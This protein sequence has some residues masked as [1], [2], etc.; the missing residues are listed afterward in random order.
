MR[1]LVVCIYACS[2]ALLPGM[3]R[4]QQPSPQ[5][6]GR[7]VRSSDSLPLQGVEVQLIP[8]FVAG[9]LNFQKAISDAGG[10]YQFFGVKEGTYSI[11]ATA[12]GYVS[13]TYKRD[14][15]PES[16][17][18]QIDVSTRIKGIDFRLEPEAV[19]QGSVVNPERKPVEG[20]SVA[21]VRKE[22]REDG[23]Q[24]LLPV[25]AT[26]T[27]VEGHFAL[28]GLPSGTYFVCV[29]GPQGFGLYTDASVAY[30]ETWYASAATIEGAIPLSLHQ[31]QQLT[32]LQIAVEQERLFHVIVRP[33]GP[34]AAPE[35]DRYDVIL[36]NR[37]HSST[38]M[39]DGSYMI[40][41][42]PA[43]HYTVV[44]TAWSGTTYVGQGEAEFN[45]VDADVTVDVAVGGLG[46]V[47]G[48][49]TEEAGTARPIVDVMIGIT[50]QEG[51]AQGKKITA[52]RSFQFDGVL[53]GRYSFRLLQPLDHLKLGSVRC[54][55]VEVNLA[56]PLLVGAEQ[57]ITGCTVSLIQ[58]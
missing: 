15:S 18:T 35:I 57:R 54:M 30:Q 42:I 1:I 48:V 27:D 25:S 2:L 53:P 14:T 45:V 50:S 9:T 44:S 51:A 4:T 21:A 31:G 6:Q 22:T 11:V 40:P 49:V 33:S 23:S 28:K 10:Y 20:V 29:D 38:R 3:A 46:K 43:G 56:A 47:A 58:N 5:I 55:G 41:D 52:D 13:V 37:N 32:G 8:P 24:R 12:K 16:E 17:F 36:Q 7:I 34:R 19:I 26:R 39:K